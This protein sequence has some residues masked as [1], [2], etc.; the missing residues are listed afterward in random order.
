MNGTNE[1]VLI[2]GGARGQGRSHA[3]AFA[4]RGADVVLC[5]LAAPIGSAPYQLGTSDDLEQTKKAVEAAGARCLALTADVRDAAEMEDVA[6]RAVAEFGH[7]DVACAN[8][9]I[10]SFGSV[11]DLPVETWQDMIDVNLTGV[12][13]TARAV[14]PTML[15]QQY[16]RIVA[17]ASMA[18]R[19][20]YANISHYVAAKWGVIGFIKSL[21][22]ELAPHGVTANVVAPTN[23]DSAMI[24]NE[25]VWGLFAGADRP[26][27][28]EAAEEACSAMTAQGIPWVQPADVT[29]AVLF[30]ADRANSVITGEVL[31]V[32][33]GANAHNSA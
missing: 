27:T 33:A 13:N 11:R 7:I 8:A 28:R 4:E 10:L 29:R 32:A 26:A 1:V 25:A 15:G 18:G 21:A 22:V 20:G 23:V 3:I 24:Q 5:D 14:V 6:A 31:H 16:G 30:L 17:T 9:G 2:T 19:G 12:F